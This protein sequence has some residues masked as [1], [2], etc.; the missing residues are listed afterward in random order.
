[1]C[2][3]IFVFLFRSLWDSQESL[4]C[5]AF[6]GSRV[7]PEREPSGAALNTAALAKES[8]RLLL[9]EFLANVQVYY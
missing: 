4:G 6:D 5:V 1:M 9:K 7:F 3:H 2:L 8:L